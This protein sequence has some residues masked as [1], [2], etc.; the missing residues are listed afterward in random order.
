MTPVAEGEHV[1]AVGWLHP[2]HPYTTGEVPGEF[3]VRL[4]EFVA[5]SAQSAEALWFGA[6][7]GLHTCEFCGQVHGVNNFGVL[8]D[9][10]LFVAPE[11][12]V[13]YVQRHGYRPPEEFIAAVLRSPL[14]DTDEYQL[15]SEPY[16]HMHREFI[17]R[18][19]RDA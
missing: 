16:W 19:M 10:A 9:D 6:A 12:V 4:K 14:P 7:A 15:L 18:A 2:D 5:R 8:G 3:V 13:H 1:R 11:M 17:E